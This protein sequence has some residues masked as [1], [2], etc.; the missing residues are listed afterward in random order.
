M[1]GSANTAFDVLED[2]HAAG[3]Q[4]TMNVRSPTYIVPVDYVCDKMSLGAYDFGVEAADN[5]FLTLPASVDGQL[6]RGM[7]AM[8]ASKEPKRYEALEAAGFPVLDSS[9]P[10]SALMH[11]LLEKAGGHYVDV[12]GTKLLAERKAGIKAGVEPVAYTATG[13]RFSD[14]STV[15]ADAIVWCTGFSDGNLR[16]T[17]EEILGGSQ[18][19]VSETAHESK[20]L[21]GP[22]E[23]AER[24]DA[25]WGID[26]EGE[27]RGMWKRHLRLDNF[28]VMGGY[29]QQHRWHSRTL[30]LQIKAAL[31]GI[32]PPAYRDTPSP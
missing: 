20:H 23:L 1:I 27:I 9:H 8:F 32:L 22:H 17:A 24:V 3:L 12:G 4:P 19:E 16:G 6:A 2:C 31:A 15:D 13:L 14:G 26:D 10:T 18:S 11:N 29:T 25:T 21:L 28:W 30:A 7:F 5:L